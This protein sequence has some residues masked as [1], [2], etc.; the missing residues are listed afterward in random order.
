[1]GAQGLTHVAPLRIFNFAASHPQHVAILALTSFP[2]ALSKPFLHTA[3]VRGS[4]SDRNKSVVTDSPY[5][6]WHEHD[7][8][9]ISPA[10]QERWTD[11][12]LQHAQLAQVKLRDASC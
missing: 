11:F 12:R 10:A 7:R 3:Q 2:S 1:M 9:Q 6:S 4:S 5:C 8:T